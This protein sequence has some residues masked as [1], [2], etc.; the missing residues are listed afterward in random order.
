MMI[1]R[2]CYFYIKVTRYRKTT[3]RVYQTDYKHG[4]FLVA[5]PTEAEAKAEV[6]RLIAERDKP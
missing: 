3:Y 2:M 5:Y 4:K 1:M 6:K